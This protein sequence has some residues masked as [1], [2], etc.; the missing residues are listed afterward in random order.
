M[1]PAVASKPTGDRICFAHICERV[2]DGVAIASAQVGGWM[3]MGRAI[4]NAVI[5]RIRK[6]SSH[7]SS[8]LTETSV[9]TPPYW[10][11]QRDTWPNEE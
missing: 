4:T 10:I 8:K 5:G 1:T 2:F 3:Q 6:S 11:L 7:N 9:P